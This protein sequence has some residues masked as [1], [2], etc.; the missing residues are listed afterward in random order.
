MV[1]IFIWSFASI[2]QVFIVF[3]PSFFFGIQT[4]H[5][6]KAYIVGMILNHA[7]HHLVH[8]PPEKDSATQKSRLLML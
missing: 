7:L 4:Q 8:L 5:F 3:Y 2:N 6:H 1:F